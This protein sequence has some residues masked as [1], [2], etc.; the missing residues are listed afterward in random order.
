MGVTIVY[1]AYRGLVMPSDSFADRFGE[2]QN[3]VSALLGGLN[4][5][6]KGVP[7]EIRAL[8]YLPIVVA[9]AAGF[10]LRPR[11][12]AWRVVLLG[13]GFAIGGV[14]PLSFSGGVEPRLL[15]V[16]EIGMATA[17]AGLA[18]VYAEAIAA[19]RAADRHVGVVTGVVAIVTVVAVAT[20]G[21]SQVEAQD[22]YRP[23]GQLSLD[24][25]LLIWQNEEALARVD[26]ENVER[27]REH[28]LEAGLIDEQ[29]RVVDGTEPGD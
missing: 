21:V 25:D 13:V 24:K 3:P 26:P 17:V 20:L 12:R 10:V 22:V 1:L 27:I 16:A 18:A 14:L 2:T 19:A 29:G 8:P 23:G 15:Y 6:V 28:L 4:S 7:W 5:V 9:F 11:A